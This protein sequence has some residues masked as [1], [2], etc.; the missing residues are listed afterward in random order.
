MFRPYVRV[1]EPALAAARTLPAS[2][3]SVYELE[4]ERENMSNREAISSPLL[5]VGMPVAAL[6]CKIAVPPGKKSIKA[7]LRS[8]GNRSEIGL[9]SR[10]ELR[11]GSA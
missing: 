1:P 10:C 7:M 11:G 8:A 9:S 2:I 6:P 3:G 4:S 5:S